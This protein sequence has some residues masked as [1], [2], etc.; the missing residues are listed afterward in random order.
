MKRFLYTLLALFL[1][2]SMG[3]TQDTRN[4]APREPSG[5][6]IGRIDKPWAVGYFDDVVLSNIPLSKLDRTLTLTN[7]SLQM[8]Y[9]D[10]VMV[11]GEVCGIYHKGKVQVDNVLNLNTNAQD[12]ITYESW[13]GNVNSITVPHWRPVY[14]GILN[15]PLHPFITNG[16]A[17]MVMGETN[18]WITAVDET[19]VNVSFE[20]PIPQSDYDYG[21]DVYI[22]DYGYDIYVVSGYVY[23]VWTEVGT[24]EWVSPITTTNAEVLIVGGGGSGGNGL[25][26]G[27]G[28]GGLILLHTNIVE[29]NTYVNYVG[30]GGASSTNNR[31]AGF[32]GENSFWGDIIAYGGGGG[33]AWDDRNGRSGGSGGGSA[34]TTRSSSTNSQGNPGGIFNGDYRTGGGGGYSQQ[35]EDGIAIA[36][37]RGGNGGDGWD[38]TEWLCGL[39]L[40]DDGWFAGGGGGTDYQS[41]RIGLGGKGGGG[42]GSRYTNHDVTA[43]K[44]NTGGGGGATGDNNQ[45]SGAG[46]SGIVILRTLL[47][48]EPPSPLHLSPIS[49]TIASHDTTNFITTFEWESYL[50]DTTNYL[51]YLGSTYTN[52]S[53]IASTT[54]TSLTVNLLDY[55]DYVNQTTFWK[56]EAQ[57]VPGV[58]TGEVWY[59]YQHLNFIY[60]IDDVRGVELRE[61]GLYGGYLTFDYATPQP[62]TSAGSRNWRGVSSHDG[63][64]MY[65]AVDNNYIYKS[66]DGG[67][68]WTALTS[69]GSRRWLDV[70]SHDGVTVYGAAYNNYIYKS[71]DGGETWTALTS[72]GSR[73]WQGVSSHDGVTAYG[74][75][76]G[77]YI[78]KSI[79]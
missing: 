14:N 73:Y 18:R 25:G 7:M 5:A 11:P 40:G 54:N 77:N 49:P 43:G 19:G 10:S 15:A 66:T 56:V 37:V 79:G 26:G 44:P 34:N 42:K 16:G 50:P 58:A 53:Q 75:V 55:T 28:A 63:V 71:T 65:G 67:E 74:A 32:N 46:G 30:A 70:S 59:F 6:D 41:N 72:A 62:L 20:P 27:G 22:P 52:L 33:G 36:P 23:R 12:R 1:F 35:G 64:T 61:D 21:P 51:F 17:Y 45:N 48:E 68:T 4:I 57:A 47:T 8:G 60:P 38:G 39:S 2:V 13:K 78:H 24:N 29:G 9:N 69:A 3:L 76:G 31:R